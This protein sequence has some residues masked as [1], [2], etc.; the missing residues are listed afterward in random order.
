MPTIQMQLHDR[1]Y[2]ELLNDTDEKTGTKAI[3]K[4][5]KMHR[6]LVN[7]LEEKTKFFLEAERELA[8]LRMMI[9]KK[10]DIDREL[11][12]MAD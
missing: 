8:E 2:E 6:D 9:R 1:E 4:C 12:K 10:Y 5:I 3:M 11:L 7:N